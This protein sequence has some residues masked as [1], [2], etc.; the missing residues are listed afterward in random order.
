MI[1]IILISLLLCI[2]SL[3]PAQ[4]LSL[5]SPIR[6]LALGDSYTIGHSVAVDQRW[7]LQLSD[8]MR[9]RAYVVDT[10]HIIARTGWTT[11]NLQTD[12]SGKGLDKEGYNLV[13]LLIGVNNQFQGIAV[14][15]YLIEFPALLDSCIRYAGNDPSK[16]FVVSIPDY[17]FTPFGN[18]NPATTQGIDLYN[19]LNDSMT[20]SRGVA[21]FNITPISRQGLINTSLVATDGLHPSGLQYTEWVKLILAY[22]DSTHSTAIS[23]T[24]APKT[25]TIYPI[26]SKDTIRI[27]GVNQQTADCLR[28]MDLTGKVVIETPIGK[29]EITELNIGDLPDGAY[30]VVALF[31]DQ[32]V[33][34]ASILLGE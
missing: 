1:R 7:P 8:S 22:I 19:M 12:I 10:T 2:S 15:W 17:A 29:A 11:K 33:A 23:P 16:V 3:A 4:T 25:L 5:T 13:S 28:V 34:R 9:A 18:G 31:Q 26:P 27:Q 30:I 14:E 32:I 20:A 21:Y 6:Y 24:L